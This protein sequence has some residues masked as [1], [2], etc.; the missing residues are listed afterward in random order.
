[1]VVSKMHTHVL[2]KQYAEEQIVKIV[3]LKE[4]IIKWRISNIV[5]VSTVCI[6]NNRHETVYMCLNT[7]FFPTTGYARVL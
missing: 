1:M 5:R 4:K 6:T 7:R 2:T 3:E